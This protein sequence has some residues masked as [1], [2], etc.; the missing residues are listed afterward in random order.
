MY[1][2]SHRTPSWQE[3][4]TLNNRARVGNRDL[5][6]ERIHTFEGAYIKHFTHD[7]FVQT[8]LFYLINQKQIHNIAENNQY[9]NSDKDNHL[10]GAEVEYKGKLTPRDSIYFNLSYING[11]N[12]Y[13][14]TLSQVSHL[15]LKGYYIYNLWEN[16]SLSTVAKYNSHKHR[17]SYD[18]RDDI[19][20]FT[21]ID[22]TLSFYN[23][24]NKYRLSL[25]VKNIFDKDV[26]YMSK[27]YTYEDDYPSVGRSFALSF[28]KEF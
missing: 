26:S 12:S 4:Y 24:S 27:P 21:V 5:E 15:L 28:S 19:T 13:D 3:L 8:T 2:T 25:G 20:G 6:A 23:Y 10:Y 18:N 11:E 7:S 16:L 1:A 14:Q 22:S 9:I 17:L